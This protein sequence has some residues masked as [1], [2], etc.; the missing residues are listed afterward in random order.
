M[1]HLRL[2]VV[3][4][5]LF[6]FK[7][8]KLN[9]V[10]LEDDRI[11]VSIKRV[12]K[13]SDCPKCSRRCSNT[14]E[15]YE[16]R[17]RDLD[18]S[19]KRCFLNFTERKIKCGCGY[20]GIEKLGFVGRY[21]RCTKRFEDYVS[22]LCKMMSLKDVSSVTGIDWK[23]AKNIDKKYLKQLVADLKLQN[24]GK[25]GVDEIAYRKGHKYL[26]VV[27]DLDKGTVI[28]VHEGRKEETLDLFFK[29]LGKLKSYSIK[30]AVI[31]MWD[32]YIASIK[33][34]TGAEIVFDKFHIAK[35]INEALD[36]VRKQE[37]ANAS[38]DERKNFK[39]KRF[40]I[41]YRNER[42][43]EEKKEKLNDLMVKNDRLYQAYLLKEQA[44]DIFDEQ[45]EKI[46]L[47]RLEMWF[48]NVKNGGFKQFDSVAGTLK[49][50]FYGI[51]NYFKHHLTN[52]ASEGFNNKINVIKRRAYG[53]HDL[54]YFKLKILQS[55]GYRA[56]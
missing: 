50:Y 35:K 43:T 23:T 13:T 55:C 26:T 1:A 27:R 4:H 15:E 39:E 28:W 6:G 33:E 22:S 51:K 7:G 42:L 32:P 40:I 18:I 17:V 36:D 38:P 41:L 24:P 29:E 16:R 52:A 54:E 20:R 5:K 14:E 45:D 9:E 37:F 31:D 53:F 2:S 49:R 25:I 11:L 56:S 30:V 19:G 47:E 34:N 48:A 10:A 8:Y 12:R 46:A 21:D 44:L 3:F